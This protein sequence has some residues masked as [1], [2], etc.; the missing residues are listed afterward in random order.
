M[1]TLCQDTNRHDSLRT[2]PAFAA[3]FDILVA[4]ARSE[5]LPL[6]GVTASFVAL[7]RVLD[8][9]VTPQTTDFATNPLEIY[10][11][12]PLPSHMSLRQLQRD[13]KCWDSVLT[14]A[15]TASTQPAPLQPHLHLETGPFPKTE[16]VVFDHLASWLRN[17]RCNTSDNTLN[18]KQAAYLLLVASWLQAT[19]NK[20]WG[21]STT[22]PPF[23][24]SLLLGGPGTGKTFV[25]NLAIELLH[26]FSPDSTLR[27]AY[28]HRAARLIGGQTLHACLALPFD[29]TSTSAAAASL[30]KQKEALQLLWRHISTFLID[31]AS[32]LSNEVIALTDLRCRQI[33][34]VAA[35][36]W[37]GLA[38][39]F[40]GDF[41][42]LPPV[43]AT[44]LIQPL[45]ATA[46]STAAL[47]ASQLQ[48]ALG[49]DIWRQITTVLILD[50]SHRCQG[51]LSQFL[52]DLA[53]D[54]G[55]TASSWQHLQ[56]RLLQ[57]NDTRLLDSK[58]Q[59]RTCPV[60]VMRHTI[61][62][63]KTLQRAQQAAA[64]A[65]HRLLLSIAADRCSF[66]NRDVYLTPALAQEAAS[67]HTLSVTANLPGLLALY[68]GIE[69]CLETRLCPELGVVRGCTVL[70]EDII[71]ADNEPYLDFVWL[72]PSPILT[73]SASKV[74]SARCQSPSASSSSCA[75]CPFASRTRCFVGQTCCPWPRSIRF[76]SC[77]SRMEILSAASSSRCCSI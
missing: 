29:S 57:A 50:H 30:G 45:T 71:L 10:T 68:L 47:I 40:S 59:P 67:V 65:G 63:M 38:V 73:Y 13:E 22:A 74:L 51:P 48:A 69:L 53:S 12:W 4:I 41:H 64:A 24:S 31:E 16:T 18:L 20:T 43:G 49:A 62:A 44:C 14:N 21:V 35:V 55:V 1:P 56:S 75:H 3:T 32:M 70:V 42:Q 76:E 17:G 37:G 39:R 52:Q 6:P 34:N 19:L 27:A 11:G 60:R 26:F 77:H 54:K 36:L 66:G 15:S 28:T 33:V 46:T 58:F 8:D 5:L 25:S 23:Q 7:F 2:S 72:Y 61:R 9:A